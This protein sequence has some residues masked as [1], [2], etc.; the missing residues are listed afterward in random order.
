[1]TQGET[2]NLPSEWFLTFVIIFQNWSQVAVICT[3]YLAKPL[4]RLE[5]ILKVQHCLSFPIPPNLTISRHFTHS[6][7]FSV[8]QP[9]HLPHRWSHVFGLLQILVMLLISWI[10]IFLIS[11][12]DLVSVLWKLMCICKF[13]LRENVLSHCEHP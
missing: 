5:H 3:Q 13:D 12:S 4:K 9:G 7:Q 2:K 6:P 10:L 1:M 11:K 8:L